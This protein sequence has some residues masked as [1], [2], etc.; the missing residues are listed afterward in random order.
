M[1]LESDLKESSKAFLELA[2]PKISEQIGGGEIMPVETVTD[3]TFADTLDQLAGIDAWQIFG[4][5]DGIRGIASRMQKDRNYQSFT[6]RY[7]RM[8]GSETEWAK[9]L[10]AID[11]GHG[12]LLPYLTIQGYYNTTYHNLLSVAAIRTLDL[13]EFMRPFERDAVAYR[14]WE[15]SC[16]KSW[17]PPCFPPSCYMQRVRGQGNWFFVCPWRC[18]KAKCK[19]WSADEERREKALSKLCERS[20]PLLSQL[21][22]DLK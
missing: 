18:V 21:F 3:S 14:E 1:R 11:S 9:R 7:R 5:R 17:P 19:I 22:L 6:V 10:K 2:W 20:D 4:N 13:F 8:H 15:D 16:L 12:A